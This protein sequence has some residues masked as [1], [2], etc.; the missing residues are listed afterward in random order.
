MTLWALHVSIYI[1][2]NKIMKSFEDV[3][4]VTFTKIMNKDLFV[5]VS[6]WLLRA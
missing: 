5:Y 3:Y 6:L 4:I 2:V 1:Y